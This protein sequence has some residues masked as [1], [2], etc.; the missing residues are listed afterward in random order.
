M[1]RFKSL[2]LQGYKTFA[3]R[4]LFEFSERITAI[5][6]PNGSG[7]SNI[8]DSIRWV[9]GEQSYS[10]LRGKRTEDMIFTGSELRSRAGMASATITFDNSDGWLPIDF[11]EV[12]VTRRA[13]RDGQNEYLINRQKVRL[14]DV[15][16]LLAQAGLAER[17]YTIIGQGLVDAA[18]ALKAEERRRLFEEAAGIHLYRLRKEEA[19]RRL[20]ATRRNLERI[21]DILAELK[22]RMDSLERQAQRQREYEQIRSALRDQLREWYGYHW[23]VAQKELGEAIEASRALESILAKARQE[24]E[25]LA[26]REA[27][28][29][30]DLQARRIKL[31]SWHHEMAAL[32]NAW[33]ETSK[34][35]AVLEERQR[36]SK[37]QLEDA[38]R[39]LNNLQEDLALTQQQADDLRCQWD[40]LNAELDDAK[41][42]LLRSKE[43][44]ASRQAERETVEKEIQATRQQLVSISN[45]LHQSQV[46]LSEKETLRD[47]I[48]ESLS[49]SEEAIHKAEQERGAV[50]GQ[51]TKAEEALETA[52]SE[53]QAVEERL[54]RLRRQIEE[55]E[56]KKKATFDQRSLLKAE[57]ERLTARLEVLEQSDA[58]FLGYADGAR[59]LLQA[60]RA[61]KL[62][63]IRSALSR[64]LEAP[65]QFE[66]AIAAALGEY[67]DAVVIDS[68][69]EPILDLLVG[70]SRRG[71][72][73]PVG[74]LARFQPAPV[75]PQEGI[76]GLACDLVQV[77]DQLKPIVNL[78]LGDCL[79]VQDRRLALQIL[80][81]IKVQ[82]EIRPELMNVSRIVTL[83]GEV[84]DLSG[85]VTAGASGG[86]KS[87][88]N[89]HQ[90][91]LA[92]SR[93][94]REIREAIKQKSG[95][96][97]ASDE[98]LRSIRDELENM[99][100]AEGALARELSLAREKEKSAS[101]RFRQERLNLDQFDR[102]L[103]WQIEQKKR[104]QADLARLEQEILQLNMQVSKAAAEQ[105]RA[106]EALKLQNRELLQLSVDEQRELFMHWSTQ[107]TVL[108][109]MRIDRQ[110]ILQDA[111][112]ALEK[113]KTRQSSSFARSSE[114]ENEMDQI[115]REKA[116]LRLREDDLSCQ[117]ETLQTLVEPAEKDLEK[118]ELDQ[119]AMQAELSNARQSLSTAETNLSQVKMQQSRRQEALDSLRRKIE[120]DFGLVAFEF[121]DEVSG[122]TP[123]PLE[124]M[125]EQ[126][127]RL[128]RVSLELEENIRRHRALIRRLG[129][130][131]PEAIRE[132]QEVKQRY[133]FLSDQV[134]DME[135]AEKDIR[136]VIRE[137]DGIM[138]EEFK[139]TFDAVAE[140]FRTTFSR[141]FKGGRA[142][143]LLTNSNDLTETGIEIEAR[144]PGRRLQG[145]SLLSGGE[146]SLTAAALVFA[147]LKVSPT[148]FCVMDEVDAMLDEANVGRFSELL[149]E[150]SEQTQFV[151]VTHNRNTVQVADVIYGVTMGRDSTSQVLSL[152]I[153]DVK[154]LVE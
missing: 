15:A 91:I 96:A 126:L 46:H 65:V 95:E 149:R 3:N 116:A 70:Q 113:L 145:L 50:Y 112:T 28:L 71:I 51:F 130:I 39:E 20:D 74:S 140:E 10:L 42:Q 125:V 124:G 100:I 82:R 153:E 54:N 9:L 13:Y 127:P 53:V 98:E 49:A 40:E 44:F 16:E 61:G 108:E 111:F 75:S 90:N 43:E 23:H 106:E 56:G 83:K 19:L 115:E 33:E 110:K 78:L 63:G 85:I 35:L 97:L 122:Q 58:T 94:L 86:G 2:E 8:A 79:V 107:V 142:Q 132:H 60:A 128:E 118:L 99:R 21:T 59:L 72:L 119:A 4:T 12:A 93:Q 151:V 135:Q 104:R 141:L 25:R 129:P 103:A 131:N 48:L 137:L 11:S 57:E 77:P 67:L 81:E 55:L 87:G 7:K 144:L 62:S 27:H 139:K 136:Q 69:L 1:L 29:R 52:A 152:K 31:T 47:Q 138:Q 76:S 38:R 88:E 22:P 105:S 18:L 17:T 36:H 154:D 73:L 68:D 5:V 114:L 84:F 6:G 89:D 143:L 14:R 26:E 80:E 66:T 133:A 120:D 41:H 30:Q 109:R 32:H 117:I 102:Q 150:L 34:R 134:I 37:S 123:L 121:E 146:R 148:P 101:Q 24:V 147:L 45:T 64:S 92:R